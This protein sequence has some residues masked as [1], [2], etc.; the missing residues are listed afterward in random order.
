M[1]CSTSRPPTSVEARSK[2]ASPSINSW[3]SFSHRRA[4]LP[5]PC[6]MSYA[7]ATSRARRTSRSDSVGV[8]PP[9]LRLR[10]RVV[11]EG[12]PPRRLR[13][14]PPRQRQP[15]HPAW[16]TEGRGE[17]SPRPLPGQGWARGRGRFLAC[18]SPSWSP[19]GKW[20]L[21][22]WK[23]CSDSCPHRARWPRYRNEFANPVEKLPFIAGEG[24]GAPLCRPSSAALPALPG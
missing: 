18:M 23:Q 6:I 21:P 9:D 19:H 4:A 3:G 11:G 24:L 14:A 10:E 5:S 12:R 22:T 17:P 8:S 1:S 13:G 2:G 7:I 20:E 15:L 16:R